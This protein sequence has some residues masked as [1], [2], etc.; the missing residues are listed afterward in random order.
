MTFQ[1]E[2]EEFGKLVNQIKSIDCENGRWSTENG[3]YTF[4]ANADFD[5]KDK[6]F[7]RATITEETKTLEYKF[8]SY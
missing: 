8:C 3:T 2:E 6:Y 5:G 4:V 1:F 7:F